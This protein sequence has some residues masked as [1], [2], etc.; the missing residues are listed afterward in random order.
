MLILELLAEAFIPEAKEPKE[1]EPITVSKSADDR[2]EVATK[3]K[4]EPTLSV[5]FEI[6]KHLVE[7]SG[8]K[9]KITNLKGKVTDKTSIYDMYRAKP[10]RF[11]ATSEKLSDEELETL[12]VKVRDDAVTAMTK[13]QKA[14]AAAK[15]KRETPAYKKEVN[16]VRA[17]AAKAKT[18]DL[19]ATYGKGTWKRTSIKQEGGDDGYSY[20]LRV[21]GV[22]KMSGLT[23]REAEAEQR[24][25]ANAIAKREKIGKYA[26]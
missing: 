7:K 2:W 6:A 20:V 4:T 15:A 16:A 9:V 10:S 25:A 11:F 24:S 12:L 1:I 14:L 18:D 21:D 19:E 26:E 5:I 23:K 13:R 3:A 17:K 22:K 8:S